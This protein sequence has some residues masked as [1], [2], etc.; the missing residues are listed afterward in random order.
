MANTNTVIQDFSRKVIVNTRYHQTATSES[1]DWTTLVDV[2]TLKKS[3]RRD[4]VGLKIM[5]ICGSISGHGTSND[6]DT[7]TV[8][9]GDSGNRT[10]FTYDSESESPL[11]LE[12]YNGLEATNEIHA[13]SNGDLKIAF[14]ETASTGSS[15]PS[16]NLAV[17]S[18]YNLIIEAVKIF[19]ND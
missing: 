4:C 12:D 1:Q 16:G 17:G 14:G 7:G 3:H 10:F 5:K 8:F 6:F 9:F 11:N 2:S 13:S 19:D 18:G 15:S